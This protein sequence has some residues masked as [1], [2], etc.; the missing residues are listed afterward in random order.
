MSAES[1]KEVEKITPRD[2]AELRA[3]DLA[4]SQILRARADSN[5]HPENQYLGFMSDIL[6]RGTDRAMHVPGDQGIRCQLGAMHYYYLQEEGF[7]N[8][9]TKD[10][11]W[12]GVRYELKWFLNGDTN[13][14]Y[15]VDNGVPIWNNDAYRR[16][17]RPMRTGEAP[18]LDQN[19]YIAR[20]KADDEFAQR[21]GNLGPIYGEQW[22]A[23][24][25]PYGGTTD[26]IKWIVEQLR[27]PIARYRKS[28]LVSAW[29]P[30]FLPGIAPSQEEE[31][32]LPPCHVQFQ[33]DVDEQNRL[34]LIMYQR[35]C[36]MFLGVPFN[37]ASYA[38][39]A[40]LLAQI[41]GLEAYQFIHVLA[42]AHVYH[43]HFEAVR[44]QLDRAPYPFPKLVLN[45][46]IKE[47]D[48]FQPENADDAK[49]VGYQH[50]PRLRAEMLAV[51][52]RIDNPVELRK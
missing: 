29:N 30:S 21:W 27:D 4:A 14:K 7:P 24:K 20:I 51:G 36:D 23:W 17:Q 16:Y 32:S 1:T 3:A 52:G 41:N 26:Q 19:E 48:D 38:L 45:P 31:V 8:L 9:T 18:Q 22:R 10:M 15:L 43:E 40:H 34:T 50:H 25:N 35:S 28:N 42:N 13:I 37:I 12:R 44:E 5:P 6:L 2:T 33:T 11:A 39:L 47:I 49:L 46:D